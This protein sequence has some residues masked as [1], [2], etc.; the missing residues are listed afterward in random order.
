[1][2]C[3][4]IILKRTDDNIPPLKNR[5]AG[6]TSMIK[7]ENVTKIFPSKKG[8][9]VTALDNVTISVNKGEIHGVIGY[10]GAGKSTLIR[11]VNLLE[12][13]SK[14]KVWIDGI[15]LT[16]LS[17]E[18]L[19]QTRQKVGM[20][21]QHFNLLKTATVYDNIAIP[22]KLL[23][24]PKSKIA[25]RVVKYLEIVDLVEKKKILTLLSFPVVRSS[26]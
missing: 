9:D 7:L 18:K 23:G 1:M 16:K 6:R 14:G 3:A 24:V 2:N 11:C 10:S 19:R 8:K 4:D 26:V 17:K 13:P 15:D 20:I 21:F 12:T 25:E 22:L 5:K